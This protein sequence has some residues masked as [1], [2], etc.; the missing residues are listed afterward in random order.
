VKEVDMLARR[1]V[2]VS[3][4]MAMALACGLGC[5]KK[6]ETSKSKSEASAPQ[7][8]AVPP[9]SQSSP[10]QPSDNA[11]RGIP[12]TQSEVPAAPARPQ[13]ETRTVAAGTNVTGSLQSSVSTTTSQVGQRVVLATVEPV[14]SGGQVVIPAGS[15][16]IGKVTYVQAA[17]RVKGGA[18]ITMRFQKLETPDGKTYAIA[19]EP[20]RLVTKGSGKQSAVMIGGGAAAGGVLGGVLGG[21]KSVLPGAAIGGILG[22]GAAVA[23][24]G[25]Q[26]ELP[27]GTKFAIQLSEPVGVQVAA[28]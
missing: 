15:K 1:I 5:A 4:L 6:D 12:N 28:K 9:P 24:K 27:E 13:S 26:I 14:R 23:T 22:T 19:T 2:G 3:L 21:K 11:V 7:Q 8:T 10:S 16:L 25:K 20:F 18:A 17:G